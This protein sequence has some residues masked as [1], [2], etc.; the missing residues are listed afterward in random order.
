MGVL[1]HKSQVKSGNSSHDHSDRYDI[2]HVDMYFTVHNIGVPYNIHSHTLD[3]IL[4][5]FQYLADSVYFL[6]NRSDH[7][8][9][10]S[11]K[12]PETRLRGMYGIS[13][14]QYPLLLQVNGEL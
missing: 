8:F 13:L 14:D 4:I 12:P 7:Q 2:N 1:H 3:I 10:L 9:L 6:A 5:T 11:A